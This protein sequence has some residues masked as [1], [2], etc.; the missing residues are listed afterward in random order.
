MTVDA[1]VIH[2]NLRIPIPADLIPE[3]DRDRVKQIAAEAA[4]T[5]IADYMLQ[6]D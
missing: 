6:R 2:L 5:A 3:E 4:V 1:E